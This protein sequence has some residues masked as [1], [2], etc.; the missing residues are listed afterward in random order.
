MQK[1]YHTIQQIP[2]KMC[3][4]CKLYRPFAHFSKDKYRPSGYTNECKDCR[5]K[6]SP[7]KEGNLFQITLFTRPCTKCGIEKDIEEFSPGKWGL[8]RSHCK[9]CSSKSGIEYTQHLKEQGFQKISVAT[10]ICKTCGIEKPVEE[11]SIDNG[12][13]SKDGYRMYCKICWKQ[14]QQEYASENAE[15]VYE[16]NRR[17]YEANKEHHQQWQRE[18][19]L[20][21]P[22]QRIEKDARRRVLEKE[23]SEKVDYATILEKRGHFCHICGKDILP[24]HKLEFDHVIPITP[25]RGTDRE[26]GTHTTDNIKPSH[27]VC[28]RRKLNRLL[29]EMTAWQRRGPD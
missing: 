26:P 10:K 20:A 15:A 9:D 2:T 7:R 12:V 13:R 17:W 22:M 19:N 29:E 5:N 28:N 23:N 4:T 18:Y 8:P 3:I 14:Y 21:H 6:N 1:A 25:R 24:H 11:F 27:S 16:V